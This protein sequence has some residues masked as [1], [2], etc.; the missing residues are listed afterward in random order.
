MLGFL[1]NV[2]IRTRIALALLV[3]VLGMIGFSGFVLVERRAVVSEMD[4]LQELAGIAP[5][6]SRL[7]HELQK[8]R[9]ISAGYIGSKGE[10]FGE[11][12]RE[13]WKVTD[14][15]NR[16]YAAAIGGL[17]QKGM[18]A[19]FSGKLRRVADALGRLAD[20][21]QKIVG[22]GIAGPDSAA[23][24]T[25][26]IT[27]LANVVIELVV[28]S[29]NA[30]VTTTITAYMSFLQAK[31]RMGIERAQGTIGF[32][33]G[34]FAPAVYNR[35]VTVGGEQDSFLWV[36][37]NLS[38]PEQRQALATTVAGKAVDDVARM[39]K[40]A[41]ESLSTGTLAGVDGPTWFDAITAKIDLMKN[42]EDR[43]ATDLLALTGSIGSRAQNAFFVALGVGIALLAVA[44]GL[45]TIIVRS[46]TQPIV[47]LTGNMTTLA[48]G[49]KTV[50][51]AGTKRGD[52]I[53]E[54]SR[55][56]LV[57]KEN[58]IRAD[59]LAEEQRREQEV[60][61]RR[62]KAMEVLT[63]EFDQGVGGVLGEFARASTTMREAA[64]GLAAT[65]EETS[66]QATA[67]AAAS[68]Q[69]S[70]SVN[71]VA[72]AVTEVSTSISE[73]GRQVN[74]SAEVARHAVSEAERTNGM[75][76]G[77]AESAS[78]IGEVVKLIN[79]IASQTNLLA[80]N[81]T[82]EAARAG[83]AGKGFAVVASEV[84]NLANQTAKATEEIGAQVAAVQGATKEAV[85]AIQEIGKTIGEINE[86]SAA[87][88][89]AVEE[90]D[91]ATKEIATNVHQAAT[92][93]AEVSSNIT[94][95]NQAAAETG[96]AANQVLDTVRLVGSQSETLRRQVETFLSG[97]KAA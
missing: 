90:Q 95:V 53:G 11:R 72:A 48:G 63:K 75:V 3:P 10:K 24:Y 32:S 83:E 18:S 58:I 28:L 91:A 55:A 60:K 17:D 37:D 20:T 4:A 33:A 44:A 29:T 52:E 97:I 13:Q 15:R 23:Y 56:V 96:K 39:K 68:E 76:R 73:I 1:E 88:A 43:L 22:L 9:G 31:E 42:V 89:S 71:T 92:G 64:Q 47:G 49:D 6:I 70:S 19:A 2:R 79:D 84:K 67:V 8:E 66:H 26:T 86:I 65:A 50:E 35:F 54:M 27:Q 40:I 25:G 38:T 87:I 62:Q 16:E 5:S 80:L 41:Y 30:E 57:F 85:D 93:T 94:G 46:I 14:E 82:I 45:V 36:F 34:Q 51:I 69:A 7:V 81:A 77:L 21:R 12:L 59:Q 78:R 61:E 74:R